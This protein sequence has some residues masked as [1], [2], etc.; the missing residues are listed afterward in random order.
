MKS[1]TH[2][3]TILLLLAFL[4]TIISCKD[5]TTTSSNHFAITED[6]IRIN[7]PLYTFQPYSYLEQ[8]ESA[9]LANDSFLNMT[10]VKEENE[11]IGMN[12]VV[13]EIGLQFLKTNSDFDYKMSDPF[14]RKTLYHG[15]CEY[16]KI[17][18][19][20]QEQVFFGCGTY[21][22]WKTIAGYL[23]PSGTA[24]G[25]GPQFPDYVGLIKA[26]GRNYIDI[27]NSKF[28]FPTKEFIDKIN[29][30]KE[31]CCCVII[32]RPSNPN[33]LSGTINEIENILVVASKY[34]IPVIID[35]AYGNYISLDESAIQLI[36]KHKNL[37]W[38]R[39]NSKAYGIGGIRVGA[40]AFGSKSLAA[41]FQKVHT[42][43]APDVFSVEISKQL[44]NMGD[45]ILIPLQ[46]QVK[47]MKKMLVDSLTSYGYYCL[48]S[49]DNVP[50]LMFKTNRLNLSKEF[51]KR[52][53]I[54][55]SG[56]YYKGTCKTLDSTFARIRVP[57]NEKKINSFLHVAKEI[58]N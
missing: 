10:S 46:N 12:K 53:V 58:Q 27:H 48:P 7:Q 6:S 24:I 21:D 42:P 33:G 19:L 2:T 34:G 51:I 1:N 39:S 3:I 8:L 55:R 52:Y 40:L 37:I 15:F 32:D 5:N 16:Y 20:P 35:E 31:S 41:Y 9:A 50:V 54:V 18:D 26:T 36:H 28:S 23:L 14:Y 30:L 22:L 4:L 25:L 56:E 44:F 57:L 29:E 17:K 38:M 11:F 43:V 13:T 49:H 45:N 47:I